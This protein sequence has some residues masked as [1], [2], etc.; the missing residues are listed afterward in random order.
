MNILRDEL[1]KRNVKLFSKFE[2]IEKLS[3]SVIS[4]TN[5]IFS[6]YTNHDLNHLKNVEYNINQMVSYDNLSDMEIFCLLSASWL[7]DIGMIP[8]DSELIDFDDKSKE[9]REEIR[10]KIRNSHHIRS[11]LYIENHKKELNLTDVEAIAIGRISKG[12]RKVSL[13]S[14]EDIPSIHSNNKIRVPFLAAILRIADECDISGSRESVLSEEGIDEKTKNEHYKIHHLVSDVSFDNKL[15]NINIIAYINQ[16]DDVNVLKSTKEKIQEELTN[17]IPFLTEGNVN[18]SSVKLNIIPTH[19]LLRCEIILALSKK[20]D[21]S[22]LTNSYFKEKYVKETLELLIEENIIKLEKNNT[23]ILNDDFNVFKKFFKWFLNKN[24]GEFF[25]SEYVQNI[26][27]I[28]FKYIENLFNL[29]I[30]NDNKQIK[31]KIL[32]NSPTAFYLLTFMDE[33][34]NYPN[35]N[36]SSNQNGSLMIDSILSFGLF[37]DIHRYNEFVDFDEI[38]DIADTFDFF[39]KDYFLPRIMYYKSL[40]VNNNE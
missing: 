7:H 30:T 31:I 22:S 4:R 9:E 40:Q 15:G 37:N 10:N 19:D 6:T 38:S 20:K 18:L 32:K 3:T 14:L 8:F 2:H 39:D 5:V 21:I 28:S 34:I 23:F 36:I 29:D 27:P 16:R 35:L 11:Y 25:F 24:M 12:H 26:I 1:K 17:G 33:V 13:S